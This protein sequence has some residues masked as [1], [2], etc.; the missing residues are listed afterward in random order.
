MGNK[1]NDI[2]CC[3]CCYFD[4]AITSL[5]EFVVDI[6]TIVA[7]VNVVAGVVISYCN[8]CYC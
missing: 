3:C 2:C 7:F 6:A 5:G 4:S 1:Q 8:C